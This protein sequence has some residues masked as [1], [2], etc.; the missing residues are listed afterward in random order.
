MPAREVAGGFFVELHGLLLG[1]D[2]GRR[3]GGASV[4]DLRN[5]LTSGTAAFLFLRRPSMELLSMT[6]SIERIKK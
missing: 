2:A 3:L 1:G 4:S 5:S 6:K